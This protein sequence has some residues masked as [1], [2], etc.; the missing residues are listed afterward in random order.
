MLSE[1]FSN[2][3][4]S[5]LLVF[6]RIAAAIMLLPG[7]G[8]A[9]IPA[10]IRLLFAAVFAVVI[11]PSVIDT[12]PPQPD[13]FLELVIV[14]VTEIVIGLFLGG[15]ARLIVTAL[16]VAGVIVGFQSSLGNAQFFDPMNAQQGSV[17]GAFFNIL[18]IFLIFA[19]DLHHL[20]LGALAESYLVFTPTAVP[21]IGDFA[22]TAARIM[23]QS[24]VLA[25]QIAAPVLIVIT[26]FYVG[27]GLLGRLM[28]QMQVFFVAMPLQI[29]LAF[30]VTVLTLSAG[31]LWFLE[32]FQNTILSIVGQG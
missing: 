2:D 13:G 19:S 31:M 15:L 3:I 8:E 11:T 17:V 9:Y 29:S 24:F 30:F 5:L 21:P 18:G 14:L 32:H 4:F 22:D 23:S 6:A 7:F 25:M 16:H 28:P 1:L 26:V 27:L 20:M 10:R 12:L